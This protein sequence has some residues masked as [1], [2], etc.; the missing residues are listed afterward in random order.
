[1]SLIRKLAG[2]TAVYGMSS[3]L[4][5]LLNYV[6]LVPYLTRVF[7]P[8]SYGIISDLYTYAAF[9][10]VIFT[11]RFETA[12]FRF[13]DKQSLYKDP[14]YDT[15]NTWVLL[16]SVALVLP[17]FLFAGTIAEWLQYPGSPDYVWWLALILLVD[18]LSA[19][20]F[21]QL[22]LA[23][24]PARFALAKTLGILANIA[25][26]FFFLNL[27][28][29][30]ARK[31]WNWF[32]QIYDPYNRV[33]YVF[34]ANLFGSAVT[35]LFLWPEIKRI[36]W[37]LD[38]SI[39]NKMWNYA[40][41]LIVVG[42]AAAINQVSN[43]PMMKWLLPGEQQE[44]QAQIGVYSACSKIAVL[45]NLFIQAFNYASEPF[46][47]RHAKRED[48]KPIYAQVAQAFTLTGS[49]V[50]LGIMLYLDV[51]QYLLG[52]EFRSGLHIVPVLLMA[53]LSL[54]L[55]YSFSVWYKLTDNTNAGAWISVSAAMLTLGSN[56]LLIPMYGIAGAAWA[57]LITYLYMTVTSYF[58]G[59]KYYRIDYPVYS[60][61]W[62]VGL[63]MGLYALSVVIRPRFEGNLPWILLVNTG[64]MLLYLVLIYATLGKT[65]REMFGRGGTESA[66]DLDSPT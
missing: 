66:A 63:A 24:K 35:L 16:S 61:L 9:G 27:C 42:I 18:A 30:L 54:G 41:P 51:V 38:K 14:V 23:N 62:M 32:G 50:F 55:Y 7:D 31:G 1:M 21:A 47:F 22:R 12:Y 10:A 34:I 39:W 46:F 11:C 48:A 56:A 43:I 33:A 65:L 3:I 6:V 52:D 19:I 36:K 57:N 53:F 17:L 26:V 4:S 28:P 45:M 49:M 25:G 5:R 44:N 29:Q 15:A 37:K 59:Q 13:A 64:L 2:E 40:W 58:L 20:P 60:M 8:S